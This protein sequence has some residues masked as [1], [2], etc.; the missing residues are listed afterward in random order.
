MDQQILHGMIRRILAKPKQFVI[1]MV[2]TMI[3]FT[4]F[5]QTY[6]S[7]GVSGGYDKTFNHLTNLNY[8]NTDA[9]PDYNFGAEAIINF[10]ERMRVRTDVHYSNL[11]FTRDYNTVSTD[12]RSRDYSTL[13]ISNLTI[14]P[15]FDYKFATLGKIDIYASA[16]VKFEFELGKYETTYLANGDKAEN[17]Y[18]SDS[19]TKTQAGGVAG[20]LFKYKLSDYT[21]LFLTPE[22]TC[23]FD[24]FHAQNDYV[25]QRVGV[26]FGIEWKF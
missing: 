22:Y 7:L 24:K 17:S 6:F 3:S 5:S 1:V 21:A 23:F 9:F 4:G 20:L 10:G 12:P 25:M 2:L 11:G 19:F 18:I 13:A 15:K 14:S 16:G 8:E 26:N